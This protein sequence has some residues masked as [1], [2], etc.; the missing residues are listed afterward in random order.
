M[1]S[2]AYF[3]FLTGD[4]IY[5]INWTFQDLYFDSRIAEVF[6]LLCTDDEYYTHHTPAVVDRSPVFVL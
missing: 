1:K 3:L 4:I 2:M 5:V 6:I